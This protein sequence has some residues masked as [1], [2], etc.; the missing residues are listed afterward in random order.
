[1]QVQRAGWILFLSSLHS[2]NIDPCMILPLLY[3]PLCPSILFY[4]TDFNVF[5]KVLQNEYDCFRFLL[6]PHALGPADSVLSTLT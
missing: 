4:L 2:I 6:F 3:S 1:M 5:M